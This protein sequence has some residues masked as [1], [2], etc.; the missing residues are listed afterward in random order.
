MYFGKLRDNSKN[1]VNN[2]KNFECLPKKVACIPSAVVM[3]TAIGINPK[4]PQGIE[5]V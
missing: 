5:I 2:D 1:I 3:T 4:C